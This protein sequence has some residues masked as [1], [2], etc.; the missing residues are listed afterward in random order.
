MKPLF[1]IILSLTLGLHNLPAQTTNKWDTVNVPAVPLEIRCFYVDTV[2]NELYVGGRILKDTVGG[3]TWQQQCILKYDGN[4]WD[5]LG[6]FNDQVL[7]MVVYN[8]ELYAGGYFTNLYG[9]PAKHLAKYT[10][11]TW[12]AMGNFNSTVWNLRVIDGE[13]YA[14]WA[15]S[16]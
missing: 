8:G 6:L 12:Q 1:L 5:T 14:I 3:F 7:A 4:Q 10:G 2:A 13:L 11:S 16:G 9:Q 15:A